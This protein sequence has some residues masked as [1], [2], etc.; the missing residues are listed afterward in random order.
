MKAD[1]N[2]DYFKNLRDLDLNYPNPCFNQIELD[3]KR[4]HMDEDQDPDLFIGKLR[5]VLHCYVK[6][7]PRIGYC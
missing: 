2:I 3:L 1:W 7:N 6:R 5:N 4:T